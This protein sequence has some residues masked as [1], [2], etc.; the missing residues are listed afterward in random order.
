MDETG[1]LMGQ[2]LLQREGKRQ[3]VRIKEAGNARKIKGA[4]ARFSGGAPESV[5]VN[6]AQ[7]YVALHGPEYEL[8]DEG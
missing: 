5:H 8:R 1:D 4:K 7:L 2:L 3:P 6:R